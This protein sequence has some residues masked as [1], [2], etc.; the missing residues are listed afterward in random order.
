MPRAYRLGQRQAAI[1][2]TRR[3]IIE[4]A[5]DLLMSP[6]GYARFTIENVARQADVARKTVYYQFGSKIGLLEALCDALA[7]SGGM[8]RM[9]NAFRQPD[10]RAA[11]TEFLRILS[12]FW[13]ADRALTRHLRGLA[14]LDP[15]FAQV[16]HDRDEWRR[17]GVRV[18]LQ[19]LAGAPALLASD[20]LDEMVDIL[21]ALL[22]FETF[23]M[24]AGPAR[25][26]EAVT[27]LVERMVRAVL[28][29]GEG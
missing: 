16:I 2:A 11:L 29:L 15:D 21:F 9:P 7:A 6:D 3:R 24:L 12:H 25:G 14:A 20:A 5:R 10:P 4:A 28:G 8:E 23:D 18:I 22:S 19:R 13:E 26:I 17:M 1:D 27:P